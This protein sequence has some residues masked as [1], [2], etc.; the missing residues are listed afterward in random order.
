MGSEARRMRDEALRMRTE[1]DRFR[2]AVEEAHLECR[3]LNMQNTELHQQLKH[4]QHA[5]RDSKSMAD[6]A[7]RELEKLRQWIGEAQSESRRLSIE[8]Q[9]SDWKLTEVRNMLE[10]SE[11]SCQQLKAMNE[12]LANEH[13][14]MKD[15]VVMLESLGDLKAQSAR[16]EK[17]Q[18][19]KLQAREEAK[20]SAK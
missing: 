20:Q 15:K 1:R 12:D 13:S 2:A 14:T 6:A 17:V 5:L 11:Q 10:A 7:R 3:R 9:E 18:Q 8:V 19:E 4:T 16:F